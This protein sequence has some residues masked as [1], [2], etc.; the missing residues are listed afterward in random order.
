MFF[1]KLCSFFLGFLELKYIEKNGVR[2][3]HECTGFKRPHCREDV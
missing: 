2:L 1:S 3:I